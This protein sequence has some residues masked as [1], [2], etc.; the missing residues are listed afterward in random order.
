MNKSK[1]FLQIIA[2]LGEIVM[3]MKNALGK[4]DD[5]SIKGNSPLNNL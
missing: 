5:T 3:K 2:C 4:H 1:S